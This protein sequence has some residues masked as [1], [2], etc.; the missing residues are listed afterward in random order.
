M[1]PDFLRR[2]VD[3]QIYSVHAPGLPA[4]IAPAFALFGYRG[5]VVFLALMVAAGT[6]AAW[7]A[8]FRFTASPSAAWVGWAAVALSTPVFFHAYTVFPDG[9][10]AA[11]ATLAVLTLVVLDT[12]GVPATAAVVGVGVALAALPWLHTRFVLVAG[13]LGVALGLR[14]WRR[15]HG[16]ARVATFFAAPAISALAWLWSFHAI[17]GTM[18]PAAPYGG[19]TQTALA[20]LQPGL[21]GI[22][23]DQQFGLAANAPVYMAAFAGIAA[24]WTR[25]RRL[26]IELAVLVVPYVLAVASYR[27][28]WGASARRDDLPSRC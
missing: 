3:G 19:Q 1:R 5:V 25:S 16:G 28:W 17:Y 24:V 20:Y 7:L 6:A 27:V 11:L 10:G 4:L 22:L 2:G 13:V 21:P 26:A 14:L 23:F 18:S 15:P 9:V 8:A 12:G